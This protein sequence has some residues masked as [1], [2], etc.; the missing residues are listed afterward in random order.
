MSMKDLT[1]AIDIVEA[2][3]GL[4]FFAGPRDSAL[5]AAA[6]ESLGAKF[7]P[8]YREFLQR[9]GAGNSGSFEIYGITN[10]N[11]QNATVPNGIWLTLK[12]R[13]DCNI[14]PSLVVI[15][16]SGD[17]GYY[18][19]ELCA[20]HEGP[21]VLYYP[22]QTATQQRPQRV[23]TDFGEYFSAGVREQLLMNRPG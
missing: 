16:D 4:G 11:F 9:F 19:I 13:S 23:A 15:G 20:G 7:P 3:K 18:A 21:V 22:G 17:G 1:E 12:Q 14:S 5:I 10:G 6:E 8:T 2:N